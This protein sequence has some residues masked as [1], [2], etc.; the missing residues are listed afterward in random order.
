M[1]RFSQR[2]L[3]GRN[4]EIAAG[5]GPEFTGWAVKVVFECQNKPRHSVAQAFS[6]P[7]TGFRFASSSFNVDAR[8]FPEFAAQRV[9]IQA[10]PVLCAGE[11]FFHALLYFQIFLDIQ[12]QNS[13]D[14]CRAHHSLIFTRRMESLHLVSSSSSVI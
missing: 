1:Q 12:L 8:I 4:L 6:A 13:L 10:Y 5:V 14:C 3:L 11:N 7:P 9:E 2:K